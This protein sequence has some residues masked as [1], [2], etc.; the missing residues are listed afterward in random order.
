LGALCFVGLAADYYFTEA[1]LP[2]PSSLRRDAAGT[3]NCTNGRSRNW[4]ELSIGFGLISEDEIATSALRPHYERNRSRQAQYDDVS[5]FAL[6]L[7]E[8]EAWRV[9]TM[10]YRRRPTWRLSNGVI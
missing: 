9:T 3:S 10:K 5:R 1:A 7:F 4:Q 6:V 2:G 8:P